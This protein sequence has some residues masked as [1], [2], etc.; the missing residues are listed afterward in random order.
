[1]EIDARSAAR[2]AADRQLLSLILDHE[3][4]VLVHAVRHGYHHRRGRRDLAL[5]LLEARHQ[6][7]E[8][9]ILRLDQRLLSLDLLVE[10]RRELLVVERFRIE[11]LA[12]A[13]DLALDLD[14]VCCLLLAVWVGG[15]GGH[16]PRRDPVG[17]RRVRRILLV[18]RGL[19]DPRES[20]LV[21]AALVV[22]SIAYPGS[23][24][25]LA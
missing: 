1:M 11:R 6:L 10:Q 4:L 22:H 13:L 19:R 16:E 12:L 21:A 25:A 2:W 8:L 14:L 23:H 17:V 9:R 20:L 24:E 15:G 18:A 3:L 5:E 7:G